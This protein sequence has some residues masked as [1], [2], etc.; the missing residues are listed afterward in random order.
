MAVFGRLVKLYAILGADGVLSVIIHNR[1]EIISRCVGV[2]GCRSIIVDRLSH[3]KNVEEVRPEAQRLTS[4]PS[5][6]APVRKYSDPCCT[7]LSVSLQ[8]ST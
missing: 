8:S 6:N 2:C 4:I 1:R 5:P 3:C 7:Y